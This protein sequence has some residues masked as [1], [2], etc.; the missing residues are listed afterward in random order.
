MKT[1]VFGNPTETK[2]I[3]VHANAYPP[4]CY[5][6]LLTQLSEKYELWAVEQ[7]PLWQTNEDP[8]QTLK[9][10]ELFSDD[11]INYLEKREVKSAVGVGHSFGAMVVIYAAL[12]RPELFSQLVLIEPPILPQSLLD[13]IYSG[14]YEPH[15]FPMVAKAL[16]RRTTWQTIEEVW[17]S[18]REKPLFGRFSD[19]A[20]WACV[21]GCVEN[22]ADGVR[23]RYPISWESRV[24]ALPPADIWATL[25]DIS[26]PTL[27]LRAELSDT[28]SEEAWQ[29]WQAIHPSIT[30]KQ[31]AS[32]GHLLP[33][34]APREVAETVLDWVDCK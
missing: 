18:W 10:W 2:L 14:H 7:R 29:A 3:F 1:H 16:K 23:L 6:P 25:Q 19:E 31:F 12:K 8:W 33:M 27:A 4:L 30:F 32:W 17:K 9:S 20:L 28:I 13:L 15:L 21:E 34:E 24:Y 11:L 26:H 22:S 5:L